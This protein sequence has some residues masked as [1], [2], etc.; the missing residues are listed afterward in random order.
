MTRNWR[1]ITADKHSNALEWEDR[2]TLDFYLT[3]LIVFTDSFIVS[4]HTVAKKERTND[5]PHY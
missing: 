1:S 3:L 5:A 4:S 2:S